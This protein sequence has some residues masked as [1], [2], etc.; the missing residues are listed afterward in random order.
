MYHFASTGMTN[1]IHHSDESD[2]RLHILVYF[3]PILVN[4]FPSFVMYV[5]VCNCQR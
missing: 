2:K 1:S 5:R 3:R 4:I